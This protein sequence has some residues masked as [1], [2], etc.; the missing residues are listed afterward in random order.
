MSAED[1]TADDVAWRWHDNVIHGLQFELGEPE[2]GD[3]RS[4]LVFDIDLIVEWLCSAPDAV[5][6]RIAPATVTFHDVTDLAIA[7]D[8][9]DSGGR[10]ALVEWS[11]HRVERQRLERPMDYWRWTIHLNGPAEGSIRFCASGFTEARTGEARVLAEQRL[12]RSE[13]RGR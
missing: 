13:R 7:V 1:T 3:W 5:R 11:I 12:P 4:N 6:F 10:T 9:G 2:N 8:Q